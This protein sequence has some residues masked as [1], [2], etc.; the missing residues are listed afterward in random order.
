M[1]SDV[2]IGGGI[3]EL[4]RYYKKSTHLLRI[5]YFVEFLVLGNATDL[6]KMFFSLYNRLL[7]GGKSKRVLPIP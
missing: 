3:D 7:L 1:L 2:G 6:Q 5:F 4:S